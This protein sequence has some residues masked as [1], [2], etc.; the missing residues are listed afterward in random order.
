MPQ[1]A[2]AAAPAVLALPIERIRPGAGQARSRFDAAA[3]AELAASIAVNG[4]IQ[5]VVVQGDAEAGYRL[6][7]GERRWRAAQKAGLASLPAILR[8]DLNEDDATVLGLIENLQRESLGLMDTAHGLAR[9]YEAH[10]LTHEQMAQRIG[11]SR[12]YVTNYLRLR[13]LAP[14]VQQIVDE[15]GLSLGHAKILA[16]LAPPRQLAL[17]RR[18]AQ[19]GLSVRALERSARD[20]AAAKPEPPPADHGMAELERGLS[21]LVGNRVEIRYDADR[22]RGSLSIAFHDLDEFDGL[23]ERLGYRAEP[24]SG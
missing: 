17:A 18:A 15:A 6:L 23:L 3:I 14:A 12:V 4:V 11:K 21:E 24:G 22:R 20:E 19:S 13:Q 10:G 16:G 2:D 5:P 7:A 9:L 1:P 8:N